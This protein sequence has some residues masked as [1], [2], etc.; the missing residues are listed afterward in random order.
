MLACGAVNKGIVQQLLNHLQNKE[1][2]KAK[3]RIKRQEEIC[4][5]MKLTDKVLI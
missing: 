3:N 1:R 4:E 2:G 5:A